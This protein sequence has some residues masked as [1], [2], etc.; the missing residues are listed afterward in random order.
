[1]GRL[2]VIIA[3]VVAVLCGGLLTGTSSAG[4]VE[5]RDDYS[6][7]SPGLRALLEDVRDGRL[8]EQ[9]FVNHGYAKLGWQGNPPQR[10]RDDHITEQERAVLGLAIDSVMERLPHSVRNGIRNRVAN[11]AFDEDKPREQARPVPQGWA[12]TGEG[13][14]ATQ[15]GEAA[16]LAVPP[17]QCGQNLRAGAIGTFHCRHLTAGFEI[18]YNLDGPRPVNSYDGAVTDFREGIADDGIPNYIQ[19][20]AV[21]FEMA[22]DTYTA[23][24]Y[25]RPGTDKILVVFGPEGAGAHDGFTP[26]TDLIGR[27]SIFMGHQ[28]DEWS[29]A[30]HE[31]FHVI[32]YA[33]KPPRSIANIPGNLIPLQAWMESTAE[34][35]THQAVKDDAYLPTTG[36][37][38]AYASNITDFLGRP[39]ESITHWDGLA[40][41]RQ[42]GGFVFAEFLE[43]RF[44]AVAVR[45]VWERIDT[46]ED[47]DPGLVISAVVAELGSS[48]VHEMI[49]FGIAAYQLCGQ[50]RGGPSP[51]AVWH[52]TDPDIPAWCDLLGRDARTAAADPFPAMPRPARDVRRLSGDGKASGDL[53]LEEGGSAY[54]DIMVPGPTSS[55]AWKTWIVDIKAKV[56]EQAGSVQLTPI[57]W[58]NFPARAVPDEGSTPVPDAHHR[59]T[60]GPCASQ[61]QALTLVFTHFRADLVDY[62]QPD[63]KI[64]WETAFDGIDAAGISNGTVA[65]GVN[66]YGTLHEQGCAPSS[67]EGTTAVGL[68]YLPTGG[69]GLAHVDQNEECKCEGWGVNVS[70]PGGVPAYSGWARGPWISGA[71]G[72]ANRVTPVSFES[73]DTTAKSVVTVE[74]PY[75]TTTLEQEFGPSPVKE[76]YQV[77]VTV[78]TTGEAADLPHVTLRRV[79]NW[80]ADPT[81]RQ[82]YVTVRA[83]DPQVEY[84]SDDGLASAD[85]QA[86]RTK[87]REDGEFTD[88]GPYDQG[89]LFDLA[90]PMSHDPVEGLV[91]RVT[92]YY[93]AA[94]D[95]PAAYGAFG[96]LG[97]RTWSIAKPV[98]SGDPGT[99]NT[100]MFGFK[101]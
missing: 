5:P 97:I 85:P 64:H 61:V 14:E 83:G 35:A 48:I 20:A 75:G 54:V 9:P 39:H 56:E 27:S 18:W 50:A 16:A 65:L 94:P 47:A 74:S 88:A 38:Y 40:Q 81:P 19:R 51:G 96:Q 57:L 2:G 46:S 93:G 78:R 15:R 44:G 12:T 100:Y 34:W 55:G 87:I 53:V 42:Y 58:G 52:L 43:E 99:P 70:H 95:Q 67:G 72:V 36:K 69:E 62:R 7:F 76:L 6:Q 41:G 23:L 59:F 17:V 45:K 71:P 79:L 82:E 86:G 31:V 25:R 91:G 11:H 28:A 84:S 63:A 1:M 73:T 4:T 24:G 30:R 92:R 33:Y 80:N 26:P 66:K 98:T 37:R 60:M 29:T 89:A 101:P 13:I 21:S 22:L 8:N 68:R 77:K 90:I 32:Q 10:Y 49:D 3:T